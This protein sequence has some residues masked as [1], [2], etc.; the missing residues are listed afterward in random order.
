MR[1]HSRCTGATAAVLRPLLKR[2]G[3]AALLATAMALPSTAQAAPTYVGEVVMTGLL[4]PRGLTFDATGRILVSEAGEGG[5]DCSVAPA[6]PLIPPVTNRCWGQTGAVVRYDPSTNTSSRPWSA[7][8]SIARSSNPSN[9]SP[10]AGLMDLTYTDD[11][12]LLGVFGYRGDPA[13]RPTGGSLF[14]TLVEFK[15]TGP[16]GPTVESLADLGAYESSHPSHSP[17]FSNP[18]ALAWKSGVS[19]ITDAG[20][21]RLLKV[22]DGT[23][24]VERL[25]DFP[26]IAPPIGA[27]AV[28][29]GLAV[30]PDGTLY[31]T[32][33]PGFPFAPN[34]ASIFSST[35][36]PNTAVAIS[37]GLTNVMDLS[38]GA[39]GW[40]YLVQYAED[41]S[42]PIGT[43]SLRRFN[44][45]TMAHQVLA[46][47]IDRPTGVVALPDGTVYVSTG[48]STTSGAL[49]RYTPGPLPI[50][51]AVLAW[52]QAR[53]LRRRIK[54]TGRIG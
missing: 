1:F 43:G 27:E 35:G 39:D 40:L 22:S 20:A 38:L 3:F 30:S 10:V 41:F 19:Y 45:L 28:P 24:I 47:N 52:R 11:G 14:A 21:N 17:A 31:I 53:V 4:N 49:V 5:A 29:T 13:T 18:F 46:Q 9:L 12:R 6:P 8:D 26:N 36:A 42:S 50:A 15:E 32:Q 25:E 54:G 37:G 51:G 23:S 2:A 7:L 34:S 48:G 44:P 33:L 16:S